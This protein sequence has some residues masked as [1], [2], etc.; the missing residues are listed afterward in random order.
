MQALIGKILPR[1][2]QCIRHY[3]LP[4]DSGPHLPP[5]GAH[6][7]RGHYAVLTVAVT[8]MPSTA[9]PVCRIEYSGVPRVHVPATSCSLFMPPTSYSQQTRPASGVYE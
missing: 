4:P 7:F 5:Y 1:P 3:Y 2:G 8:P 9:S 6:H